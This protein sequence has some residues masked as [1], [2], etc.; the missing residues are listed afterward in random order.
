MAISLIL[1][2]QDDEIDDRIPQRSK[3][4]IS[5]RPAD[6]HGPDLSRSMLE[7]GFQVAHQSQTGFIVI[8]D[9]SNLDVDWKT[10][11]ALHG[12]RGEE[13]A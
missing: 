8:G 12:L 7:G 11:A 10:H 13:H 4:P 2:I 6:P 5:C 3:E 9:R 1:L